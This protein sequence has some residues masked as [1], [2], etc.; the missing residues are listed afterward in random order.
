M[1]AKKQQAEMK[2]A[3]KQANEDKGLILIITG[4]GK[5]KSSSGFGM[6]ARSLGH[7]FKVGVVQF[8]KGAFRTGEERFF[9]DLPDVEYHA[10]G[11]GYTWDTQD[12]EEDKRR[13]E[14]GWEIAKRLITTHDV[15]LLDELCVA[16]QLGQLDVSMVVEELLKKPYD[17]HVILTGRGAPQ[18]L[19][20][21][22]DTV[23]EVNVIKHAWTDKGIRAQKGIEF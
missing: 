7:G 10:V 1:D 19:I 6:V 21:I 13:A 15:V 16:L 5:G 3:I 11:G 4:D 17:T 8:I 22:A 23:S 2:A 20:A 14:D 18:E 9:S 12:P